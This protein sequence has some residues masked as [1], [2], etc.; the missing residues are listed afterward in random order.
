MRRFS[1]LLSL[2]LTITFFASTTMQSSLAKPYIDP[3]RTVVPFDFSII[4]QEM[5]EEF[6]KAW[7]VAKA[8]T[9]EYEG[10]VLYYLLPDGSYQVKALKSTNE[11]KKFSFTWDNRIAA[12]F[13]THPK[14]V[15][16]R[17]SVDDMKVADKYNVLMFTLT[18]RGMYVYDPGTKKTS[19]VMY[20]LDWLNASKWTDEVALKM[21]N[22]SPSFASKLAVNGSR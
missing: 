7:R 6:S 5:T 12:I 8:G 4:N 22:L 21:A 1:Y 2:S 16:P 20:G 15:D 13:H 19:V 10:V 3:P 14:S 11:Y 18:V 9:S 17:P